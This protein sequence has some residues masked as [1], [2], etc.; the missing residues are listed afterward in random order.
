MT[1]ASLEAKVTDLYLRATAPDS[2][3]GE[4]VSPNEAQALHSA[5]QQLIVHAERL[6]AALV[7]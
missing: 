4:R 5:V 3:A 2:D 1:L 6:R 7:T